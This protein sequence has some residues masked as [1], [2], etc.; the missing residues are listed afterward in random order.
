MNA[1]GRTGQPS[2]GDMG[3]RPLDTLDKVT[4]QLLLLL[5]QLRFEQGGLLCL[6]LQAGDADAQLLVLALHRIHGLLRCQP[7]QGQRGFQWLVWSMEGAK[8][9][10]K[11]LLFRRRCMQLAC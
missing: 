6:H 2:M 11:T 10:R 8:D 3:G 9:K 4:H 5:L 7:L 1:Q